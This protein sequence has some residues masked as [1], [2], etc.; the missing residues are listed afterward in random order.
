MLSISQ[1]VHYYKPKI[2]KDDELI[3]EMVKKYAYQE[4][5]WGFG[6]IMTKIKLDSYPWNHKKVYR[7]YKEL[8]LNLRVKPKKRKITRKAE[9]LVLPIKSNICWSIDFMSDSL[10]C[11]SKFRTLNVIEDY[12]RQALLVKA[13]RSLT[14]LVVTRFLEQLIQEKGSPS[15]IRVYNGPEFISYRFKQWAQDKGI[16]LR[17]IQPGKPAQN[18]Y[19]ERFNRTYREDILDAYIFDSIRDVNY[20]TKKWITKYN[21]ER[22][23]EALGNITPI[24]FAVKI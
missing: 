1:S 11:G 6:K 20:I 19:I 16:K 10:S 7:I 8:G 17:Y 3:K 4:T 14:A 12:N 18:A 24:Q 15:I 2:K 13:R 9:P 22:P 23:H 5:R 21:H